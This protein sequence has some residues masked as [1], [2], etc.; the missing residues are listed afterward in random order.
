MLDKALKGT[1]NTIGRRQPLQCLRGAGR[2]GRLPSMTVQVE[3]T[4]EN[5]AIAV[6]QLR[7]MVDFDIVLM[8]VQMPV[9]NGYEAT[10]T[11]PGA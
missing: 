5:G 4:A 6:E 8:D 1:E 2:T 3:V 7:S 10:G 11:D 9:M